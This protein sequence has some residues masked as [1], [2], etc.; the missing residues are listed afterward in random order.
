M[1]IRDSG[2]GSLVYIRHQGESQPAC[3][4]KGYHQKQYGNCHNRLFLIQQLSDD[5]PVAL[6]QP[7][8]HAGGRRILLLHR[9]EPAVAQRNN[10]H[11]G[12][13]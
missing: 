3:D 11:S 12:D 13:Q 5:I 6:L 8:N 2:N 9:T 4:H 10:G 7:A 1:C